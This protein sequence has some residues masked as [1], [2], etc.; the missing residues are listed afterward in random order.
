M[1]EEIMN[2][3]AEAVK[4]KAGTGCDI[5]FRETRKNNGVALQGIAI[6]EHGGT[7]STV[8][9]IDDLLDRIEKCSISVPDAAEEVVSIFNEDQNREELADS[10]KSLNKEMILE[11]AVYQLIGKERNADMLTDVPHRDMLDL[12]AVY[13]VVV[14]ETNDGT[15]SFLMTNSLCRTYGISKEELE[16][17]ARRNTE[18]GGFKAV[19]LSA[20]VAEITGAPEGNLDAGF[21]LMYIY[22]NAAGSN[23]A[24]VM[25]YW[26]CLDKLAHELKGDLYI[27]PSSV[28]EVIAV[29]AAEIGDP[30][31]LKDIVRE[32]NAGGTI[33]DDE[34][35]SDNVYLYS[36]KKGGLYIA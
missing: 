32:V 21:P 16:R 3:L 8:I 26:N 17:A 20:V 2:R 29:P 15:A 6:R 12:A 25:L 36:L 24:A 11:K 31:G 1:K 19:A 18:T 7:V 30:A 5:G 35:L 27:L 22:A 4:E 28:H 34:I 14:G 13:R 9:Y 10:V 23:G 33:E